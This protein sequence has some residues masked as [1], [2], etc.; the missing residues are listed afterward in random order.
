MADGDAA[1][2]SADAADDA[3]GAVAGRAPASEV[4]ELVTGIASGAGRAHAI[5]LSA[6]RVTVRSIGA[7]VVLWIIRAF[8][9]LCARSLQLASVEQRL[10]ESYTLLADNLS[11]GLAFGLVR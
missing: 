1:G 5:A 4:G 9:L 6:K 11:C 2:G 10:L 3:V 7:C 8:P